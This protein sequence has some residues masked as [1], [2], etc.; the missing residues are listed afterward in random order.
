MDEPT[1]DKPVDVTAEEEDYIEANILDVEITGEA[2]PM[3]QD[4]NL[5]SAFHPGRAN[6]TNHSFQQFIHQDIQ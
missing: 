6:A 2:P 5:V 1:A 3:F 4:N